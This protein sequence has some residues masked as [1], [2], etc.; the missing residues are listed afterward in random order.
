MFAR[1]DVSAHWLRESTRL[2]NLG[3]TDGAIQCLRT[4]KQTML[5]SDVSFP[6]ETWTKLAQYLVKAGRVEDARTELQWLLDD[7]PRR[8]A[9]S[10]RLES[11]TPGIQRR[12]RLRDIKASMKH[13]T[14]VVQQLITKLNRGV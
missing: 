11:A 12:E 3:D 6:I 1:D 13:P 10:Y 8:L 2:K 4:A 7:L 14:L 9:R 5:V